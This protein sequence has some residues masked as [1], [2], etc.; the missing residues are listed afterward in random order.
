MNKTYIL[1]IIVFSTLLVA[2]CIQIGDNE[3]TKSAKEALKTVNSRLL[4]VA[5]KVN[6]GE[7]DESLSDYNEIK[8][9]LEPYVYD[10]KVDS[11]VKEQVKQVYEQIKTKIEVINVKISIWND[12]TIISPDWM[13]GLEWIRDNTPHDSKV[14]SWWDYGYN[15]QAIA[16]RMSII[17]SGNL[18]SSR[19]IEAALFFTAKEEDQPLRYNDS[20][21]HSISVIDSTRALSLNPSIQQD[22]GTF[23]ISYA[24]PMDYIKYSNISYVILDYAMVGKYSAVSKIANQSQYIDVIADVVPPGPGQFGPFTVEGTN[25]PIVYYNT[26]TSGQ[27]F[28]INNICTQTSIIN[29]SSDGFPGC[30][31]VYS[32]RLFYVNWRQEQQPDGT[33][34]TTPSDSSAKSIFV[35][36]WFDDAKSLQHFKLVHTSPYGYVKVY[37]VIP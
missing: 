32:N 7:L 3:Q 19:V 20:I 12:P 33:Y 14:L 6:S 5:D 22:N 13:D 11:T 23:N 31:Y 37:Q 36:L 1:A 4:L 15:I 10:E 35:K 28:P 25:P 34:I 24:S 8:K 30:A 18:F 2:G 26:N 29:V 21:S 27:R 17:D 16:D 9:Q